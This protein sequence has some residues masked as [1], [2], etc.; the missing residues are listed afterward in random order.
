MNEE[1]IALAKEAKDHGLVPVHLCTCLA[2]D[3]DQTGS[4]RQKPANNPIKFR[5]FL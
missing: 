2:C 5:E 4:A 1:I 3:P